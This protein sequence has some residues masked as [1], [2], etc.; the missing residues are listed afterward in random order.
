M[1]PFCEGKKMETIKFNVSQEDKKAWEQSEEVSSSL[2]SL[3]LEADKAQKKTK[4]KRVR[5]RKISM[6]KVQNQARAID[7]QFSMDDNLE[8]LGKKQTI[9]IFDFVEAQNRGKVPIMVRRCIARVQPKMA[10]KGQDLDSSFAS[11]IQ[12]CTWV[13]QRYGFIRKGSRKYVLNKKGKD[14][15]KYHRHRRDSS[16]FEGQFARLYNS[17]FN[18]KKASKFSKDLVISGR[19]IRAKAKRAS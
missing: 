1:E 17:V 18:P 14:R 6:K 16:R 8:S 13:F 10:K 3:L 15:N 2:D 11:A 12:I 4:R 5:P 19:S 7:V 9:S